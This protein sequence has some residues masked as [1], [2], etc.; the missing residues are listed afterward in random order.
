MNQP[1]R[2]RAAEIRRASKI[3]KAEGVRVTLQCGDMKL[4]ISPLDTAPDTAAKSPL[5][6]WREKRNARQA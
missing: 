4:E 2:F 5:D 3:A 1:A 6:L